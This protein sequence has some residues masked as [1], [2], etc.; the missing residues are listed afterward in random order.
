MY[1][2]LK[3]HASYDFIRNLTTITLRNNYRM[4]DCST[5]YL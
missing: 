2:L 5:E 4:A 3:L 1:T